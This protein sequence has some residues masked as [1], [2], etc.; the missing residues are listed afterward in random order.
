MTVIFQEN[1]TNTEEQ[2]EDILR[3]SFLGDFLETDT[4]TDIS[5]NGKTLM[6]QDNIKGRY[7]PHEQPSHNEV[8]SLGR[9]IADVQGREFNNSDPILDTELAYL[10]V[11]FIHQSV[12]PSGTSFAIRISKPRLAI[13]DLTEMANEDVAKLLDVLIKGEFNTI[14]SGRTGA[15]KTELQKLLVRSIDHTKKI[16]LIEDT[17][18]SHI[19]EL[20]PEKDINSWRT[21]TQSSREN[22][23]TY[24]DLIKAGLRN[25]PDWLIVAETRGS[26]AY[27]MLE[28]A[29]TDH[30]II[31]TI[32]AKGATGIPSRLIFMIGQEYEIN[33]S[34]LGREIADTLKIGIHMAMEETDEG[35]VRFIR[36]IVEFTDF[37]INDGVSYNTLYEVKREYDAGTNKHVDV[38]EINPL[39]ED[40]LQELK[41]MGLYHLVPNVFKRSNK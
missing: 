8:F 19:K 14:I 28:S 4:I 13:S 18:D 29:L 7:K 32:H 34:L 15:G 37:N 38:I 24:R 26:E 36:E 27:D 1:F 39:S 25:N 5:F 30:A 21:L 40:S 20:Y 12:S 3:N 17:M 33:E 22:P 16:T 9:R 10:R 31:T 41:F 35:I 2:I 23:I 11:S 6:I